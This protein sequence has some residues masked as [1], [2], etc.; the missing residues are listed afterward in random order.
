MK[1]IG[2]QM[3][4]VRHYKVIAATIAGALAASLYLPAE[5][6]D[7][8]PDDTPS[9]PL[10]AAGNAIAFDIP[11]QSLAPALTAY[12]TATGIPLFYNSRLAVGRQSH[13]VK[14]TL[15]AMEALRILLGGTN[16]APIETTHN[17]ITLIVHA[18]DTVFASASPIVAPQLTL[19]TMHVAALSSGDHQF[20]ASAVRY[21]IQGALQRTSA[22]KRST[23]QVDMNVWLSSTGIIRRMDL[24]VPTGRADVDLAIVRAVHGLTISAPPPAML[25][26]PVHVSILVGGRSS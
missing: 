13:A 5:A 7:L 6:E 17:S 4:W 2:R 25:P 22:V 26:Q 10:S 11:A 19:N 20:Y 16:L 18:A 12:S 1:T 21:S 24:L 15:D 9:A 3:S 8:A 23:F 14:G